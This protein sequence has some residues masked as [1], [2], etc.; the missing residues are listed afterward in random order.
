[1]VDRVDADGAGHAIVRDYKS[2]P[3]RAEHQGGRWSTDRQLQVALYMI[4]VRQ[5]L[6]LE[7]VAGLYQPLGGD[8][9]RA[10]GIFLEGS[11]VG[12]AIVANDSRTSAELDEALTEARDRALAL[13]DR[14][15][16]GE[17]TPCPQTCSRNGCSYPGICRN[18]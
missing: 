5:L 16:S 13:A 18:G 1:M 7:P 6:G 3:R 8:D 10:R 4:A 12:T 17:L 9:L 11:D 15:R 14:I 2:G